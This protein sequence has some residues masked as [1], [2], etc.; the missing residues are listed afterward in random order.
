MGARIRPEAAQDAGAIE[1]VTIEAFTAS[2]HGNHGEHLIV[3]ALRKAGA[4]TLSLVAEL[5]AR[6]VGH[7]A[8]SPVRISS[9]TE[10]WFGLGPVSVCPARRNLGIGS[11]LVREA[12]RQLLAARAAGCVVL[13]EPRYYGRFGFRARDDL[14]LPEVPKECFQAIAFRGDWPQGVVAYHAAFAAG[15]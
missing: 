15:S 5:D 8:I 7:L 13:G 14:T 1:A 4:L 12:L 6:I 11:A 9:G 3:A 10:G 2:A